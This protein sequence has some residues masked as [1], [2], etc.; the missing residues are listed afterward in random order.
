[1]SGFEGH[2][3]QAPFTFTVSLSNPSYQTITVDYDTAD[4]TATV[5]DNDYPA[6]LESRWAF[7]TED[8]SENVTVQVNGDVTVEPDENFFVDLSNAVNATIADPQ[9]GDDPERRP[10]RRRRLHDHR[11]EPGRRPRRH[12][13]ER[14]HL[15]PGGRRHD[16]RR[17]RS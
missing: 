6:G 17:G 4:G 16:L 15:R 9:G 2:F 11:D 12:S 1:M 13:R 14:R 5:A 8:T 7:L 3:G 10:V